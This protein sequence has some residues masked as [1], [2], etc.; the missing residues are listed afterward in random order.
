MRKLKGASALPSMLLI[1]GIILEVVIAGLVVSQL[2]SKGLLGERLSL[3]AL[4]AAE[5]GAY[6]AILRV[7]SYINCPDATYCPSLYTISVGERSACVSIGSISDGQMTINSRGSAFTRQK[8]LQ[9]V[10]DISTSDARV[11]VQLFREVET[12]SG[13]FDSCE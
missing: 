12:P 9:A 3:E 13:I 5:S 4:K 8:T 1:S 6:D 11:D 7:R 10:L 2:F